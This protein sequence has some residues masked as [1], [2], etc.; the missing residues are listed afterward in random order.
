M[1]C[2]SIAKEV[3]FASLGF[4]YR[5]KKK[6][7]K[8][9]S[10]NNLKPLVSNLICSSRPDETGIFLFKV[11]WNPVNMDIKATSHSVR[12]IRVSVCRAGVPLYFSN[13]TSSRR[14]NTRVRA[15]KR[16]GK[17]NNNKKIRSYYL[18]TA[19]Y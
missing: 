2:E 11:Q 14:S 6:R 1:P 4:V 10:C 7:L 9:S 13:P 8:K 16:R 5:F 17:Q 12:I 15:K 18:N 3:S 19:L